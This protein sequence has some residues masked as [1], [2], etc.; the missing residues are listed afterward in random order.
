VA[1][2]ETMALAPVRLGKYR[3]ERQLAVGGMA[4]VYLAVAEG[5]SGFEKQVVVKRLLPQ[6]MSDGDLVAMFCDEARLLSKLRH[7]N[8][9]EVHDLGLQGDDIYIV[10]EHVDGIDL[11]DLLNATQGGLPMGEALAV[12]IAVAEGLAYAHSRT[13]GAGQP[14]EIVH[15]DVSPSN[16]IVAR[17]G[18]VKLIDFG[19]AKWSAQR[20]ETRHGTLKGKVHYMSPEQ[21][22][23]A[24]IDRRSDVFALGVLLYELTTGQRP[25]SGDN[26]YDIIGA[27][28]AGR[29][30]PPSARQSTYDSR[31]EKLVMRALATLPEERTPDAGTL[32]LE[33]RQLAESAGWILS[34]DALASR[35]A[36]IADSAVPGVA[37]DSGLSGAMRE[38]AG[39][40][41]AVDRTLTEAA[42]A[43]VPAPLVPG[44]SRTRSASIRRR[45]NRLKI[46]LG[47]GFAGLV[48]A[49]ALVAATANRDDPRV[50]PASL[51]PAEPRPAAA[52]PSMPTPVE[53]KAPAP[54][55]P[56]RRVPGIR[57]ARGVEAAPVQAP[58]SEPVAAT[59]VP[60][61]TAEPAPTKKVWDPDSPIPP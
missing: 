53:A 59:P 16:V 41:A 32:A 29:A 10:L 42:A 5:T 45:R 34:Y 17:D 9:A 27:I 8:I 23:S 19:V 51:P 43:P 4:E 56:V 48:L 24:P 44:D 58:V 39:A 36:R 33:L 28:V 61:A 37:L 60:S 1:Q 21:C 47:F 25:F 12:V 13:D 18:R 6:H 20:S 55:T 11:R 30:I 15:R 49:T 40:K 35:V 26:E 38:V 31:L 14:L 50:V 3:L 57:R 2:C 54:E 7:P 22:R 52:A 46:G